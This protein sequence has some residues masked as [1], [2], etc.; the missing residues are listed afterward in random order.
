M[1][2]PLPT[3][4]ASGLN[5]NSEFIGQGLSN[6][7]AALFGGY[8][9]SGSFIRSAIN[10]R[11]GGRTPVSGIVS[12]LAV[13]A[14]L[15]LAAPLAAELPMSSLSGVLIVVA[16]N[17]V[18]KEDIL[19]TLRATR[20]DAAVLVVTFLSTLLLNLEFAIYVGVMLSIGLHLA[21]TSHPRIHS[22]VPDMNTGKLAGSAFGEICCQMD[23]LFVEGSIFFGSAT[24][25][26]DDLQR[27]LRNHPDTANLLIRMHKVNTLDASGVHVLEVVLEEIRRRGGGFYFSAVNHRVF[28]VFKNSGLLKEVGAGHI[29]ET[30]GAAIRQAMQETFCPTVCAACQ[31]HVFQECAELKKGNWEIFGPGVRP[32]QCQ[33]SENAS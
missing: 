12:G 2:G 10:F 8:P 16:Y 27:R 1:P 13:A 32:R 18:R 5:I 26:L 28:E 7:S 24:F 17:M 4:R 9:V 22:V 25:V 14:T 19:R 23:I 31:Y 11:S 3:R 29:R 15:L 21:A 6:V 33:L 30:T 20:G